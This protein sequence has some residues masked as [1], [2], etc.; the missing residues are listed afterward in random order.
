MVLIVGC[1]SGGISP[2]DSPGG[3]PGDSGAPSDTPLEKAYYVRAGAAGAN[4]GSDW[5]N[6]WTDLPRNLERGACYYVA[7]GTYGSHLFNDAEV[8]SKVI[9]IKKATVNDHGT[10][11]GWNNAFANGQALFTAAAGPIFAFKQG[12][13]IIDG[14]TG[15]GKS[16]HGIRLYNPTNGGGH[17][18]GSIVQ[19]ANGQKARYL[20]FEHVEFEGYGCA[21]ETD[22]DA[23]TRLFYLV[24]DTS[25]LTMRYC[26]IH[27][28]G[29]QWI[30][31][32]N[33]TD[34]LIEYCYFDKCAKGGMGIKIF[35]NS[36]RMNV[37]LRYNMLGNIKAQNYIQLG[38]HNDRSSRGYEIYGNVFFMDDPLAKCG[39]FVIGN[40]SRYETFDVRIYNNTFVGIKGKSGL[41]FYNTTNSAGTAAN[42][43][44]VDCERIGF[45]KISDSNNS[46]NI[47]TSDD[48]FIN[49]RAGNYRLKQPVTG[50]TTL[51]NRYRSDPDDK[52]RGQDG[53]WDYGA[54]EY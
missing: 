16:G 19:V 40:C 24:G 53:A 45:V 34:I 9:M 4:D 8:G 42:N 10:N 28:A 3:V 11:V 44:W 50:A 12:Y 15:E 7:A 43:L 2:G 35:G 36:N 51:D 6:A 29:V 54:Y 49:A 26:Y 47:H 46:K 18:S 32:N 21:W 14:Q 22:E 23:Q 39:N 41:F 17:G 48:I 27:E 13:Y 52:I 5:T 37:V 25:H 38:E 33:S 1:S 30:Y 31:S 20:R